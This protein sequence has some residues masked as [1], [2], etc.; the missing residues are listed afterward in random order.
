MLLSA[1]GHQR[2]NRCL[3]YI[4]HKLL[5]SRLLED[6]YRAVEV[7]ISKKCH[8]EYTILCIFVGGVVMH[9]DSDICL[10]NLRVREVPKGI[11]EFLAD[12]CAIYDHSFEENISVFSNLMLL[13]RYFLIRDLSIYRAC[14]VP[15]EKH[16]VA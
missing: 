5:A 14:N 7:A 10:Y 4:F 13:S 1:S 3:L 2:R 11:D 16:L 8:R 12:E 9:V 15:L 6:F